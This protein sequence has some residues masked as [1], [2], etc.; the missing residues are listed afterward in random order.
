MKA[1]SCK[2]T[3]ALEFLSSPTEPAGTIGTQTATLADAGTASMVNDTGTGGRPPSMSLRIDAAG[4]SN[5]T[6]LNDE[7]LFLMALDSETLT[8]AL[9]DAM[10]GNEVGQPRRTLHWPPLAAGY[11]V[12]VVPA[13]RLEAICRAK[14]WGLLVPA[15]Q[16]LSGEGLDASLRMHCIEAP[17]MP[18]LAVPTAPTLP[19][20]EP[21][22][23][24][25][26][27]AE[28]QV[29]ACESAPANGEEGHAATS[30]SNDIAAQ[31]LSCRNALATSGNFAI[32]DLIDLLD[33]QG[34]ARRSYFFGSEAV[35]IDITR[36][37]IGLLGDMVAM[38]GTPQ[39]RF[40]QASLDAFGLS[41]FQWCGR[42]SNTL[43]RLAPGQRFSAGMLNLV[44]ENVINIIVLQAMC[45]SEKMR[46][47]M[48][49]IFSGM[50]TELKVNFRMSTKIKI[51]RQWA[52]GEIA[53]SSAELRALCVLKLGFNVSSDR[54]LYLIRRHAAQLSLAVMDQDDQ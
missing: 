23:R 7:F 31:L 33:D 24:N 40:D 18:A 30:V 8:E 2:Q 22:V 29:K 41:L 9:D 45:S 21:V 36:E 49:G 27:P 16:G 4:K 35:R 10:C 15:Q 26:V 48:L 12:L 39:A 6:G 47:F 37:L 52:A 1:Q 54:L 14:A 19:P 42:S 3:L 13:E 34:G 11:P 44:D 50:E 17:I 32:Q 5:F 25:I 28:W 46:D 53:L 43:R 51:I 20:T 38:H